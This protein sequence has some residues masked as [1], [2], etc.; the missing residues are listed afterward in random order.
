ML[1][2]VLWFL[3]SQ[4]TQPVSKGHCF[5]SRKQTSGSTLPL[6][7]LRTFLTL[8]EGDIHQPLIELLDLPE[9]VDHFSGGRIIHVCEVQSC[10]QSQQ[11]RGES[12]NG[13]YEQVMLAGLADWREDLREPSESA[14]QGLGRKYLKMKGKPEKYLSII[15]RVS[16]GTV[17]GLGWVLL[18]HQGS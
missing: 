13:P 5:L 1:L 2:D 9:V 3:G 7:P 8:S 14:H 18:H 12:G 10:L 6:P 11:L 16:L 15:L 4:G 17:V